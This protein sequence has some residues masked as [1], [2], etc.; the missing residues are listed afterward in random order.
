MCVWR[1]KGWRCGCV[2][3]WLAGWLCGW[4]AVWLVRAIGFDYY[5]Y[6]YSYYYYY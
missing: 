4:L 6:Y 5:Y 3:V 2:A 1:G